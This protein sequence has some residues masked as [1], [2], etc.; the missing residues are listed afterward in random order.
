MKN[1]NSIF[2]MAAMLG[3]A[4]G[5]GETM[6]IMSPTRYEHERK[7]VTKK[8]KTLNAELMNAAELK[9]QRKRDRNKSIS[10]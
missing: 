2:L 6:A 5:S 3:I 4:F 1:K 8:K 7:T 9:R 10:Q